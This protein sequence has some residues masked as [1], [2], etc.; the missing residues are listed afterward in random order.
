MRTKAKLLP[1]YACLAAVLVFVYA[2][3]VLKGGFV[4]DDWAI[5]KAAQ[6]FP[7][8]VDRVKSWFPVFSIRPVSAVYL[9][10]TGGLFGGTPL[11][12]ILTTL[13]LWFGSLFIAGSVLQKQAGPLFLPIVLFVAGVPTLSSTGIFSPAMISMAALSI[14]M[15]SV[16][17]WIWDRHVRRPRAATF[18]AAWFLI[19]LCFLTYEMVLPLLCLHFLWP[20]VLDRAAL[21]PFSPRK[22]FDYA[23]RWAAPF[24]L[25]L[26]VLYVYQKIAL[27][28]WAPEYSRLHVAL[29]EFELMKTANRALSWFTALLIEYPAMLL[30][31]PGYYAGAWARQ[32]DLWFI[33]GGTAAFVFFS[34]RAP[35]AEAKPNPVFTA[36]LALAF[37]G[38]CGLYIL[39]A[40]T[41]TVGGYNN[42][43]MIS[44]SLG[45]AFMAA[46]A[47]Q[48]L[49]RA[50]RLL[51]A[52]IF[53]PFL[54]LHVLSFA[55]QRDNMIVSW[56]LQKEVLA[57]AAAL[58]RKADLP[59]GAAVLGQV[60]FHVPRNFNDEYVFNNPFDWGYA[61]ALAT[62]GRAADGA[63]LNAFW[64][65]NHYVKITPTDL[66]IHW[67]RSP[68]ETLWLYTYKETLP[69][70]LVKIED[71]AHL[72]RV[73]QAISDA[74]RDAAPPHLA[75]NQK[76]HGAIKR[77]AL[78][79]L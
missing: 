30:S 43:G 55:A 36:A 76:I 17:F 69:S 21:A 78:R 22:L 51:F 39:S 15:W 52:V 4:C 48:K 56:S 14:F 26:A 13:A 59:P 12:Y 75:L 60:P 9:S 11:G 40:A 8:F 3:Y 16:S 67:W 72:R 18:L 2:P 54:I 49:R 6:D 44:T 5:V 41:A 70:T 65:D 35:Q 47:G 61:L 42:R 32:W 25:L 38:S 23:R 29:S 27:P 34:A 45:L 20:A 63:V 53:A 57:D 31:A 46:L 37:G 58:V 10:V 33:V 62:Q 28:L 66:T 73:V 79:S 74:P 64:I 68:Y 19:G 1:T 50:H 7:R 71:E 77:A 24:L